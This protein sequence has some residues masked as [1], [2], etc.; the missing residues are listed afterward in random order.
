MST[1]C[2]C[3]YTMLFLCVCY[4]AL[5]NLNLLLPL[6]DV[7]NIFKP[8]LIVQ[9]ALQS[10]SFNLVVITK[11]WMGSYLSFDI[12]ICTLMLILS[13]YLFTYKNN[14]WSS[15]NDG[16]FL[17]LFPVILKRKNWSYLNDIAN[18]YSFSFAISVFGSQNIYLH[19]RSLSKK[20]G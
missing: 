20:T 9:V 2:L 13:T 3:L 8:C 14:S 15:L 4:L 19:K 10:L 16:V 18:S 1:Y 12:I 7:W 5:N 6:T 11:H 17:L